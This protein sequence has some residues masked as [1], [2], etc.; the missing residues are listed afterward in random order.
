MLRQLHGHRHGP[1]MIVGMLALFLF[2]SLAVMLLWNAVMPDLLPAHTIGFLQAAGLL[3]LCRI[4]FGGLG[5]GFWGRGLR[6]HFHALSPE[7]REAF[8]RRIHE[9]F[10][11]HAHHHGR[12]EECRRRHDC[13]EERRADERQDAD[14]PGT[15]HDGK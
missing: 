2:F 6:E 10:S 14:K 7:E 8:A 3:L 15:S 9:R 11:G 13:R 4:L 1:K 12:F 5:H